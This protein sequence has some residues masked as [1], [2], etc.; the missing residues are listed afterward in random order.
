VLTAIKD[1][2]YEPLTAEELDNFEEAYP[3]I[4]KYWKDPSALDTL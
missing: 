1:G 2:V 4:A 3:D